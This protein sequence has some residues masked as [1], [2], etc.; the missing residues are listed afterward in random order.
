FDD[1]GFKAIDEWHDITDEVLDISGS[2]ETERELLGGSSSDIFTFTLDN[3]DKIFTNHNI[4]SPYHNKIKNGVRFALK[5]GFKVEKFHISFIEYV[6][7]FET[8]WRSKELL[9]KTTCP[10][11]KL[12]RTEPPKGRFRNKKLEELVMMLLEEA[13]I[14]EFF[15]IDI[16]KTN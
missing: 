10:M 3:T 9:M 15:N 13:D 14:N 12:K 11:E 7:K 4:H 16:H 6:K 8:K 1:L 2:I 5:T